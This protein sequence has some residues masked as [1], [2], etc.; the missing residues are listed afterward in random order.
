MT[1]S[2][3]FKQFTPSGII[4]DCF[5]WFLSD[6]DYA[7]LFLKAS[8]WGFFG[9]LWSWLIFICDCFSD[10]YCAD[11]WAVC[12]STCY[13]HVCLSFW[14]NSG[15]GLYE[16]SASRAT[17]VTW[18]PTCR[19]WEVFGLL[20]VSQ[21]L[22]EGCL[23]FAFAFF[24]RSAEESFR[25]DF[26]FWLDDLSSFYPSLY[27]VKHY[28]PDASY[29]SNPADG[30]YWARRA[31]KY[32][33]SWLLEPCLRVQAGPSQSSARSFLELTDVSCCSCA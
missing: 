18:C 10:F 31:L 24:L 28:Q 9:Q 17:N 3:C 29:L 15:V 5:D 19:V 1:S 6:V 23:S 4:A 7:C 12:C 26:D 8:W 33:C 2:A 30:S 14:Q 21:R 32:S 16:D 25:H 27:Q 13:Y 20:Y 11:F 22:K